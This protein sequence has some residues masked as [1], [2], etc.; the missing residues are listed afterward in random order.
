MSRA[1][2]SD[3]NHSRETE[4]LELGCLW[5]D[6]RQCNRSTGNCTAI[7]LLPFLCHLVV[8]VFFLTHI[9]CNEDCVAYSEEVS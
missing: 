1:T 6:A 3:T 7:E 5:T 8:A 4:D 2:K 9:F